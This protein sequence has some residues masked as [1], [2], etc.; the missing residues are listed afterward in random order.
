MKLN[1]L[2]ILAKQEME[3]QNPVE[4]ET[5]K[6]AV[7]TCSICFDDIQNNKKANLNSCAHVYHY[8]CI[9]VWSSVFL[10]RK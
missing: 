9:K 3:S 7:E 2:K 4:L 10:F 1:K 6:T 5:D 8:K